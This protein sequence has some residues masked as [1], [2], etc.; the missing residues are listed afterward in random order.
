MVLLQLLSLKALRK[1]Q[2]KQPNAKA[3]L[4]VKMRSTK[5][6][7]AGNHVKWGIFHCLD[8]TQEGRDNS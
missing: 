6:L 1:S 2:K 4:F 3:A 8:Y 7:T 5:A